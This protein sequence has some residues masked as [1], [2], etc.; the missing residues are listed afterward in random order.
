MSMAERPPARPDRV[1][2]VRALPPPPAGRSG[3]PWTQDVDAAPSPSPA[4]GWPRITVV[5]P[6]FNQGPYLEET[7]RSVLLQGYPDLEYIVVDGGSTDESVEVIRRYEEHL[8][9]WVS[10][11]DRGQSHAINKGLARATGHIFAYLNSDDLY[12]PGAL[13]AAA[14]AFGPGVEWV[15]GKVRCWEEGQDPWPFP[16][17]PGRGFARW[18]LGCPISQPAVL[19]SAGLHREAGPF[20]EDLQYTMDYE[21]WLRFRFALRRRPRHL[22]RA[23]ALYRMHAESKSVAH[24]A[25]MGAEIATLVR[26]YEA[27][28]SGAQRG[29]L[30][31]AR[32]HR[33]G[34][35][36]GARAVEHLRGGRVRAA[37][38]ELGAAFGAWPLLWLDPGV[39][40]ALWRSLRDSAPPPRVF[41]DIWPE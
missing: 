12:E 10:E 40:V 4:S 15:A 30:R 31:L 28:L 3:W 22:R 1:A 25:R 35:V 32:R 13:H 19:W 38:G 26:D 8:A 11:P 18:F 23:L 39:P 14:R 17:L 41:P 21:L 9:W 29:W 37:L 33:R 5:T 24:Q 7:I 16:E 27:H 36:R 2:P 34:R 20:R 6:S